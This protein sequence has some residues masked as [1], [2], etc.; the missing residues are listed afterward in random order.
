VLLFALSNPDRR[1]AVR[2]LDRG[3]A[4]LGYLDGLSADALPALTRW[5]QASC[6]IVRRMGPGDGVAG[7]NVAR[8]RARGM[9]V[10]C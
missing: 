6:A 10:T 5:P 4:D 3:G 9:Q 2:N 1:I 7:W 8:A